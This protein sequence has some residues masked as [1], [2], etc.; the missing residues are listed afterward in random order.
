MMLKGYT[1]GD[2]V[3]L[4]W[5]RWIRRSWV[6]GMAALGI[7]YGPAEV[8]MRCGREWGTAWAGLRIQ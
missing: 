8:C 2:F 6:P 7:G 1:R 4:S 3:C 5:H